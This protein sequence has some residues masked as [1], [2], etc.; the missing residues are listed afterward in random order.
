L[1]S[2]VNSETR[3]DFRIEN[4]LPKKGRRCGA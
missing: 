4:A 2:F 1:G 3:E